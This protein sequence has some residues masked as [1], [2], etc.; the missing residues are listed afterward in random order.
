M[1][2][3]MKAARGAAGMARMMGLLCVADS[4]LGEFGEG[5]RPVT[6]TGDY[7]DVA[8]VDADGRIIPWQRVA[9]LDGTEMER[10]MREIVDRLYTFLRNMDD[11]E[12]TMLRAHRQDETS[13]WH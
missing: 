11:A 4:K 1:A 3:E 9:R 6:R 7:S 5:Q 12:L 10:T 8:V 2:T 13:Q